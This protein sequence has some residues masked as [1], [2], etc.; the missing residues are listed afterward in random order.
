MLSG[1]DI[2]K[3]NRLMAINRMMALCER[4]GYSFDALILDNT[5]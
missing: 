1:G 3:E 2:S 4:W 5:D